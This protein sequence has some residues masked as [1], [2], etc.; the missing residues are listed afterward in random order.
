[1]TNSN[2]LSHHFHSLASTNQSL[3]GMEYPARSKCDDARPCQ[4]CIKYSRALTC[5]DHKKKEQ[6]KGVQRGPYKKRN[7]GLTSSGT[8]QLD[9]AEPPEQVFEN[10][11]E[12]FDSQLIPANTVPGYGQDARSS[13]PLLHNISHRKPRSNNK[14]E[15]Q[16]CGN[17]VS[18]ISPGK[19]FVEH[20]MSPLH[21]MATECGFGPFLSGDKR[22]GGDRPLSP[23]G[24]YLDGLRWEGYASL[25]KAQMASECT[26][27]QSGSPHHAF[28]WLLRTATMELEKDVS[29]SSS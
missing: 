17:P 11:L 16:T 28:H 5:V 22:Q 10:G 24:L 20:A 12:G 15:E 19:Y 21:P 9:N 23:I 27:L 8:E 6:T 25:S 29:S 3:L 18:Q 14:G 2:S 13:P 26:G 1:M 4:R 7:V